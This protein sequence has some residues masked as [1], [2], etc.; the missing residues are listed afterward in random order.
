MMC[1]EQIKYH[2][3]PYQNDDH[4]I[5]VHA[6]VVALRCYPLARFCQKDVPLS[7][8][9]IYLIKYKNISE[10]FISS[11]GSVWRYSYIEDFR[12]II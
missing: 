9:Y 3:I 1:F 6:F 4:S 7:H 12:A 11:C 5:H 10:N 8:S 2:T